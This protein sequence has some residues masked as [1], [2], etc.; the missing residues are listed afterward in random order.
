MS[1]RPHKNYPLKK[2][3]QKKGR[4]NKKKRNRAGKEIVISD[5]RLCTRL[6][7]FKLKMSKN[8]QGMGSHRTGS[9]RWR[10]GVIFA[11]IH[12]FTLS[13]MY[14]YQSFL[15][16]SIDILFYTEFHCQP[17]YTIQ[18][19][20]VRPD[21]TQLDR[22]GPTRPDSTRLERPDPTLGETTAVESQVAVSGQ[23]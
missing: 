22:P 5:Q 3:K 7:G 18:A 20:P 6:H 14:M 21:P 8:F 10:A 12:G 2:R 13:G 17:H 1:G 16:H 4:E 19:D 9:T 11:P 23:L 15:P